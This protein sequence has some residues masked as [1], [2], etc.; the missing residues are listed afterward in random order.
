MDLSKTRLIESVFAGGGEIRTLDR[1]ATVLVPIAERIARDSSSQGGRSSNANRTGEGDG[2]ME[3]SVL[4]GTG[5]ENDSL[6]V[7]V[8][9]DQKIEVARV[10]R[11]GDQPMP[12]GQ[13]LLAS[14]LS[15][16]GELPAIDTFDT[17]PL[18]LEP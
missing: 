17:D 7:T 10:A 4:F 2:Q 1:S 8:A 9:L 11:R 14:A 18:L 13:R 16:P 12:C 3:A 5:W 15:K 6:E